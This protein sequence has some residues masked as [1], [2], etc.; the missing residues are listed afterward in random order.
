MYDYIIKTFSY[1][2]NFVPWG[3]SVLAS[4]LYTC[5]KIVK[6]L[7]VFISETAWAIFSRFH[8]G[9]VEKLLIICSN[10][11]APLNKVAPM[12]I[13]GKNTWKFLF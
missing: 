3:L 5:I 8:I 11:S 7:N 9:P 4:G 13:Y 2:Q 1:N 12:P 10:D 6:F